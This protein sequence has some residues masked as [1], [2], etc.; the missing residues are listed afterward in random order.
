[1]DLLHTKRRKELDLK[2]A[3][4]TVLENDENPGIV[5]RKGSDEMLEKLNKII[6][7][8]MADGT[9]AELE[10]KWLKQ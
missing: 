10:E 8:M 6:D 1:M 4:E 5:L 2:V 3:L 7:D 9:I